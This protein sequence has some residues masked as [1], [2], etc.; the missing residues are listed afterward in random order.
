ML[1]LK[2]LSQVAFATFFIINKFTLYKIFFNAFKLET[3][4]IKFHRTATLA[5]K[6]CHKF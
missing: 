2:L 4:F 1:F 6:H 5:S 3:T